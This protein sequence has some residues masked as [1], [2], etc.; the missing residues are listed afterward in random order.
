MSGSKFKSFFGFG[1]FDSVAKTHDTPIINPMTGEPY[2]F[3]NIDDTTQSDMENMKKLSRTYSSITK[4]DILP[5]FMNIPTPEGSNKHVKE[6]D[7]LTMVGP[8]KYWVKINMQNDNYMTNDAKLEHN[9]SHV[10]YNSPFPLAHK[11]IKKWTSGAQ[12]VE[13]GVL[14]AAAKAIFGILEDHRVNHAWSQNSVGL[15]MDINNCKSKLR[16]EMN[17][18]K[19]D[20]PIT[21]MW[22]AYNG[23]FKELVGTPY[24]GMI[25]MFKKV[26]FTDERGSLAL[27]KAFYFSLFRPWVK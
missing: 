18:K 5:N 7:A 24:D 1:Y 4:K 10:L 17:D 9:I 25:D 22:Y 15:E 27:A 26:E 12:G 8:N 21:A 3:S 16:G 23:K 2:D 13:K 11:L 20:D 14:T 19:V 6:H